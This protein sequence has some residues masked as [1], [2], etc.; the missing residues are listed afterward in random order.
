MK[1]AFSLVELTIVLMVIGLIIATVSV[2]QD[3]VEQSNVKKTVGQINELQTAVRAF[4]VTYDALPGDM[5]N[6]SSYWSGVSNGDGDG[7]LDDSTEAD[8]LWYTHLTKAGIISGFTKDSGGRPLIAVIAWGI[9]L[10]YDAQ[11]SKYPSRNV[12]RFNDNIGGSTEMAGSI[13]YYIDD[14]IDDGK[15]YTGKTT[16]TSVNTDCDASGA[17]GST[18]CCADDVTMNHGSFDRTSSNM[19]EAIYQ[20]GATDCRYMFVDLEL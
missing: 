11:W 18:A 13:A 9:E 7:Q 19:T 5:N 16:A 6:A 4:N 3:M 12:F 1:K 14:K 2:A 15:P 10:V 17:D 8:A 20:F